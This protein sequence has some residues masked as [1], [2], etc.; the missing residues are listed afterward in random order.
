[1]AKV[2]NFHESIEKSLS[3]LGRHIETEKTSPDAKELQEKDVLKRSL[4]SFTEELIN[5]PAPPEEV[6]SQVSSTESLPSYLAKDDSSTNAKAEVEELINIVF[7]KGL[8]KALKTA[9]RHGPFVEDAFHDALVDKLL[10]ELKRRG[11]LS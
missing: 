1:M 7:E 9:T 3:N 5:E 8:E 10:P 6:S 4:K 2:R 11:I